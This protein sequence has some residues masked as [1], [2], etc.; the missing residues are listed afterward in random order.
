MRDRGPDRFQVLHRTSGTAGQVDDE[1]PAAGS[2]QG[3]GEEGMGSDFPAAAT[4]LLAEPREL[5]LDD[6]AGR[7]RG[8]VPGRDTGPAGGKE[9]PLIYLPRAGNRR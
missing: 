2:G 6:L 3:P 8:D 1:G 4:H 5:P 7:F 9:C